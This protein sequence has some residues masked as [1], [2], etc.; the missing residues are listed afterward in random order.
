MPP[1]APEPT[2]QSNAE[3]DLLDVML[4]QP[5]VN[6]FLRDASSKETR[7]ENVATR[8]NLTLSA[9]NDWVAPIGRASSGAGGP[10]QMSSNALFKSRV[11]SRQH[12]EIVADPVTGAIMIR[13]LD[14]MHGTFVGEKRLTSNIGLNLH[15]HSVVTFG[16]P[17]D[18]GD[19]GLP[20]LTLDTLDLPVEATFH[21]IVV[22][23]SWTWSHG[24]HKRTP[25]T[26]TLMPPTFEQLTGPIITIPAP[27]YS[28][29]ED[30]DDDFLNEHD[31]DAILPEDLSSDPPR[32]FTVPDSDGSEEEDVSLESGDS[33]EIDEISEDEEHDLEAESPTS[34]PVAISES[35][36]I[37][38]WKPSEPRDASEELES[39]S[40]RKPHPCSIAELLE[41]KV[42][43]LEPYND[44]DDD[45]WGSDEDEGSM[46]SWEAPQQAQVQNYPVADSHTATSFL[47]VSQHPREPSPSDAAMAKK[48]ASPIAPW[49]MVP[50]PLFRDP[51]FGPLP[52]V[53]LPPFAQPTPI[54][55]VSITSDPSSDS[56]FRPHR[57]GELASAP[58][59][60]VGFS[61]SDASKCASGNAEEDVNEAHSKEDSPPTDSINAVDLAVKRP[62][63]P[64][65]QLI[66]S[67]DS[68][69]ATE[70]ADNDSVLPTSP[71]P[72]GR[73]GGVFRNRNGVR[74]SGLS[75]QE[76]ASRRAKKSNL[77]KYV[78]VA[79]LGAAAGAV[80]TV[81][82]LAS[83][84]PDF[85]V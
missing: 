61:D 79:V 85:F 48:A 60:N 19:S 77:A 34:S 52:Y 54:S 20:H 4:T 42:E 67:V 53:A 83:L 18:R 72:I 65:P 26:P 58:R 22:D 32:H 56:F 73:C 17:V 2:G 80:G 14:S 10:C 78:A 9:A 25:W 30:T 28:D 75:S 43:D 71:T 27:E 46:R 15:E 62:T 81:V 70:D 31:D 23:I 76:R 49:S 11:I 51:A 38:G 74:K 84:P 39:S 40:Q 59:L 35:A 6:I 82:G 7:A 1:F 47:A 63:T 57:Y 33:D 16:T 21:P 24:L 69:E 55:S 13:D 66:K 41:D 37:H 44:K 12:A 5:S 36:N 3:R 64:I 8:R 68:I 29:L 45:L 50:P